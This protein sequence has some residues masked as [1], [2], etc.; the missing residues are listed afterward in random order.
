[1]KHILITILALSISTQIAFAKSKGIENLTRA[2]N[3]VYRGAR[4]LDLNEMQTLSNLGIK[5]ILNIQGGDMNSSLWKLISWNEP[6]EK[7]EYI[8]AEKAVAT[9]LNIGFKNIPLNSLDPVT[10]DEDKRIDQAI[11][12]LHNPNNQPVYIHC[13]HGKDRT[14]LVVALYKIKYEGM[15]VEAAYNEWV[16]LGHDK[17]ARIFT[18]D[19]DVYFA[20]KVKELGK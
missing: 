20:E 17:K 3:G 14:G 6:G 16:Q 18:G 4:P 10:V 12:F 15:S 9:Q 1:M 7:P 11:E 5:S 19:L 8:A 13:E 2:A